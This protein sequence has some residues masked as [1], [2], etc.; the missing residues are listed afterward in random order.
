MKSILFKFNKLIIIFL[1]TKTS[2]IFSSPQTKIIANLHH[3]SEKK[4]ITINGTVKLKLNKEQKDIC[5]I[6]N[7][8]E[9]K[10][11]RS[12][13]N[14]I[15]YFKALIS[16]DSQNQNMTPIPTFFFDSSIVTNG[17][18]AKRSFLM[19]KSEIEIYFTAHFTS[20]SLIEKKV[21]EYFYPI[22]L[23]HCP[24]DAFEKPE[25]LVSRIQARIKHDKSISITGPNV[26][27]SESQNNRITSRL[28][29]KAPSLAFA[30]SSFYHIDR[31]NINSLSVQMVSATKGFYQ[32]LRP[33]VIQA[34]KH[35]E[36]WFGPFPYSSL[37]I[38]EG[39]Q[40]NRADIPGLIFIGK[41]RQKI[42]QTLQ[43]SLLNWQ[44]W[45]LSSLI[46]A[47]WYGAS[48]STSS[49]DDEWLLAGASEFV[50][51]QFFRNYTRR[52]NLF[53]QYDHNSSIL[54]LN[55]NQFQHILAALL[56]R[57]GKSSQLT[58]KNVGTKMRYQDQSQY[59]F[60]KQVFLLRY[61]S[62]YLGHDKLSSII[63]SITKKHK[64]RPI[65]PNSFLFEFS[66]YLLKNNGKKTTNHLRNLVEKWWTSEGW[67]NYELKS[68]TKQQI[69]PKQW[70][71]NAQIS[72]EAP[73]DFPIQVVFNTKHNSES[74]LSN[75][76]VKN[77]QL[78]YNTQLYT[79]HE[80]ISASLDPHHHI[81]DTNRFN[82]QSI[83]PQINFFPG[84]TNT[85]DDSNYTIL[86]I[87]YLFR[88]PGESTALGLYTSLYRYLNSETTLKIELQPKST[89]GKVEA[90]YSNHLPAIK[91]QLLLHLAQN[92]FG[93]RKTSIGLSKSIDAFNPWFKT[94]VH[95]NLNYRQTVGDKQSQH[96]TLSLG[97]EFSKSVTELN[98]SI[99]VMFEGERTLDH[100]PM[101]PSY[102]KYLSKYLINL[103]LS[104]HISLKLR[105]FTGNVHSF[106]DHLPSLSKFLINDLSYAR[107]RVDRNHP[108]PLKRI[109]SSGFDFYFP[110]KHL[111]SGKFMI[112]NKGLKFRTFYD[113]GGTMSQK[114]I[115][116]V[117]GGLGF[118]L[119]FGGDIMGVGTLTFTKLSLLAVTYQRVYNKRSYRP[120]ILFDLSGEL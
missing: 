102:K 112:L 60:I 114:K 85:L 45:S 77:S 47:Q 69:T 64:H 57:S 65:S 12:L 56:H 118:A 30:S 5:F 80:P 83:W 43:Q 103:N 53:N 14:P 72:S 7:V 49:K 59:L 18:I 66:N 82:N 6:A 46:A 17:A 90:L 28:S 58:L 48:I 116:F 26:V 4:R 9:Y 36:S 61:L 75:S 91:T 29:I 24:K 11:R 1:I 52:Y 8:H 110:I 3:D 38:V 51:Y 42:F 39:H 32:L 67:P 84:N 96:P 25:L 34:L 101:R 92:Y 68:F 19:K 21:F 115:D 70:L 63:R 100:N 10:K 113:I 111:L 94:S 86:W 78:Q 87:P 108:L 97:I 79:D 81:F 50:N 89:A 16:K 105:Y 41:P 23:T 98:H 74:T 20:D 62:F 40:I 35:H 13:Y 99:K 44:H 71:A 55:Y 33:T 106:N 22:P 76:K 15:K 95:S 88:R 104:K 31:F 93:H 120:S 54:S 117:S 27:T 119:P 37:T 2:P 73:F 107:V 109:D